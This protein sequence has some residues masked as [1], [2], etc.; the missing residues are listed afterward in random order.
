MPSLAGADESLISISPS[1]VKRAL[2]SPT[3]KAAQIAPLLPGV[4]F[5]NEVDPMPTYEDDAYSTT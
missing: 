3:A 2:E 5:V 4:I 1:V